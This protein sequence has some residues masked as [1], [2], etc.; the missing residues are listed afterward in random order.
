MYSGNPSPPATDWCIIL[1]DVIW[2]RAMDLEES[3]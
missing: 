2:G 1:P 3:K